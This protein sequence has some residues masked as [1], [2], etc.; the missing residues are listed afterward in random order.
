MEQVLAVPTQK[1]MEQV[2][3]GLVKT[4]EAQV[5]EFISREGKSHDRKDALENDKSLKQ[6]VVYVLVE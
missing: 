1:V 4:D 2:A 5:L 3:M 6:I